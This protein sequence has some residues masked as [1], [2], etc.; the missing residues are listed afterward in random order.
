M[1]VFKDGI[2]YI[3]VPVFLAI[4]ELLI[5]LF[6]DGLK[7]ISSIVFKRIKKYAIIAVIITSLYWIILGFLNRELQF[8]LSNEESIQYLVIFLTTI[9]ILYGNAVVSTFI[10]WILNKFPKIVEII[11]PQKVEYARSIIMVIVASLLFLLLPLLGNIISLDRNVLVQDV[12]VKYNCS[13][14]KLLKGTYF[15]FNYKPNNKSEQKS[16]YDFVTKGTEFRIAKGTTINIFSGTKLKLEDESVRK[17]DF[18]NKEKIA[19]AIIYTTNNSTIQ[20]KE[21]EL[22]VL[23]GDALV[24]LNQTN[25]NLNLFFFQ[26]QVIDSLLLLY[27]IGDAYKRR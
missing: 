18:L 22:V 17:V 15:E 6:T 12:I 9:G 25:E 10:M 20:L 8:R 7:D 21:D 1:D 14:Y 4:I 27:Y 5:K 16:K 19:D 2:L 24:N 3:V 11:S 26:F 23:E 13:N